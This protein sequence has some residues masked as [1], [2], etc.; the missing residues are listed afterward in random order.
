MLYKEFDV[1][2]TILDSDDIKGSN[3]D[4]IFSLEFIGKNDDNKENIYYKIYNNNDLID[5]KYNIGIPRIK[6]KKLGDIILDS[7]S[8]NNNKYKIKY[9]TNNNAL[10]LNILY[11]GD[12]ISFEIIL[13]IPQKLTDMETMKNELKNM[14]NQ[15]QLIKA[16]LLLYN[17][18]DLSR[19]IDTKTDEFMKLNQEI[20]ATT[21]AIKQTQTKTMIELQDKLQEF[22]KY[23]GFLKSDIIAG[24]ADPQGPRATDDKITIPDQTVSPPALD[25]D[26]EEANDSDSITSDD[27][28]RVIRRGLLG[29]IETIEPRLYNEVADMIMEMENA[30]VLDLMQHPNKVVSK[31]NQCLRKLRTMKSPNESIGQINR[32]IGS[33]AEIL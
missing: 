32:K 15:I 4:S 2:I 17:N 33:L 24:N 10:T 14:N 1:N 6:T 26:K 25:D 7:L 9:Y 20:H 12:I 13:N 8:K 31:V 27:R 18:A 28:K 30:E 22:S 21:A 29:M 11:D 16:H 23:I 5:I 3:D 19:K